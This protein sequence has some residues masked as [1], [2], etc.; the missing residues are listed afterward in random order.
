MGGDPTTTDVGQWLKFFEGADMAVMVSIGVLAFLLERSG[1]VSD[2]VSILIPASL[3]ALWGLTEAM[4]AGYGTLAHV[5]KG[6]LTNA[7]AATLIGR[8]AH[9]VLRKY[10]D[11]TNGA[12][13][14]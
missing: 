10:W 2:L 5:V 6:V 8:G 14:P 13:K 12:P 7:G 9:V 3:G 1:R 11:A 4:S